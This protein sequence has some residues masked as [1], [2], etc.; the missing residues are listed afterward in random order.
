MKRVLLGLIVLA[1]ATPAHAANLTCTVP[2]A[3][4]SRA[5]ELCDLLRISQHV[6]SADWDNSI[7][8]SEFLRRGLRAFEATVTKAAARQAGKLQLR[9]TLNDWDTDF[10]L[11]VI[12]ARCG[13]GT[14]DSEYGEECDDGNTADEDGCD[15]SCRDE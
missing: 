1:F 8:A 14:L 2:S 9:Q 3:A 12:A 6:R 7:C 5:S 13:D 11:A 10:P 15:S 4:V